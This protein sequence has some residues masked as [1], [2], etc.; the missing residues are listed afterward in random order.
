MGHHKILSFLVL[1][2]GEGG[3]GP[4]LLLFL[5]AIIMGRITVLDHNDVEVSNLHWEV[6]HTK[7]RRQAIKSRSVRNAMRALKPT[8]SVTAMTETL[9]WYNSMKLVR[10]N[11]CVVDTSDDTC[12]QYLINNA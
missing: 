10:S 11:N 12:T 1:V 4:T 5:A 8:V 7:G 6:I 2:V 3:I 9:T